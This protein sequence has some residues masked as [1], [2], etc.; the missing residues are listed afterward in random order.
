MPDDKRPDEPTAENE[1]S[2]Y[3]LTENEIIEPKGR[4]L[5]KPKD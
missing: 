3:H 5:E 1:P 4:L 2:V